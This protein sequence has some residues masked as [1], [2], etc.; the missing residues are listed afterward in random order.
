LIQRSREMAEPNVPG[1]YTLKLYSRKGL[2]RVVGVA[3]FEIRVDVITYIVFKG[4]EKVGDWYRFGEDKDV[5]DVAAKA[6]ELDHKAE[7]YDV[8]V[9][10]G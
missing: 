10:S 1:T 9:P 2:T 4:G 3:T 7:I 8:E 5:T 6:K